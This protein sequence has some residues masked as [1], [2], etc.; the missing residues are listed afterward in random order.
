VKSGDKIAV[1]GDGKLGLLVAQALIVQGARELLHLGRHATKLRLIQGD[2]HHWEIVDESTA[3]RH[4]QVYV[5][6]VVCSAFLN[7]ALS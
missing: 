3:T 4:A 6:R 7:A 5:C 2:T 1:V